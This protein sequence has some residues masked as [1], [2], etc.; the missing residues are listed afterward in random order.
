VTEQYDQA[1]S[2]TDEHAGQGGASE[3]EA[4]EPP[5]DPRVAEVVGRLDS[6]SE[7]P[8]EEQ[9]EVYESVHRVLQE[10]LAEAAQP[11]EEH[12]PRSAPP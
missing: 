5:A 8:L 2:T 1:G 4:S 12:H 6:L 3:R 10:S 9:V 7:L 11:V